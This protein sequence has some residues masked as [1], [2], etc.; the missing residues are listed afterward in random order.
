ML[1]CVGSLLSR[2]CLMLCW[3]GCRFM[4]GCLVVLRW[5]VICRGG[6]WLVSV[7]LLFI[8]VLL[9]WFVG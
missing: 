5:L 6:C 3:F 2:C 9:K 4:F 8:Y 7:L 1:D